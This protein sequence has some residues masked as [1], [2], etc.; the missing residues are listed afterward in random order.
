[1][2]LRSAAALIVAGAAMAAALPD[3][4]AGRFY[5]GVFPGGTDGMG[6]DI[7]PAEVARYRDTVGKS[8]TWVYFSQ[9]WYEGA[10]FPERTC[11]WIREAGSIPYVR[12][13]LLSGAHIPRPDPVY[14]LSNILSGRFDAELR[15][16]MR[17]ARRFGTPLVAEYGVEANG[18]WF[19]WNGLWNREGG[20]LA[21]SV[22][23]FRRTYRHIVEL[24]REEGASNIRWVWHIDPWDDPP[25]RWNRFENYY[26]G[27]KWVDWVG[28][29]VYGM[30][31][32]NQRYY[33]AFRTQMDWVYGRLRK[34]TSKPVIVCEYGTIAG[35]RQAG[36][37]EAALADL[38]TGRWPHVIGFSWWNAGFYNDRV[39]KRAFSDMRVED[40]P[41]LIEVMRRYVGR[42]P[43]VLGQLRQT[44]KDD[45]LSY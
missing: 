22:E 17:G 16:W 23:R 6:S 24:A 26:P 41:A 36:W 18:Y 29:S 4:P 20:S 25:K 8:P 21:Q 35:P 11:Q 2:C 5:N 32:P 33:P 37:T 1:M 38:T 34:L 12:L 27:D 7:T 3:P 14:N 31:T 10:A 30:Q 15:E 42:N 45:R 44:T 9:N 39:D 19:P 40:N 28:V 43:N 13:M